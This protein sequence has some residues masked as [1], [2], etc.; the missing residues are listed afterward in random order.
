[1][2]DIHTEEPTLDLSRHIADLEG[3]TLDGGKFQSL[4]RHARNYERL[5]DLQKKV[6]EEYHS[7]MIAAAEEIQEQWQHHCDAE[8]YGP[9]NLMHRLENCIPAQYGYTFGAFTKLQSQLEEAKR[10]AIRYQRYRESI[11]GGDLIGTDDIADFDAKFDE[12]T[13]H[14]TRNVTALIPEK[15]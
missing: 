10:D 6:I 14:I 15:G 7:V 1:M 13:K 4:L 2:K 3:T 5:I 11:S 8:G 9:A 12:L